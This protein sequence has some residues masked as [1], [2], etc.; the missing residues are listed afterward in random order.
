MTVE[1]VREHL[2]LIK[3]PCDPTCPGWMICDGGLGSRIER[4]DACASTVPKNKRLSD[5]DVALLPE[6]QG[7]LSKELWDLAKK[8]QNE[9]N[10][11]K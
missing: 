4:C 2:A 8:L 9:R 5:E 1:E 3:H 7:A 11:K 6:A 10:R